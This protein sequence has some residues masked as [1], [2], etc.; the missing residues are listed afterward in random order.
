P[1]SCSLT[2]GSGLL[3]MANSSSTKK[4]LRSLF[5]KSE[6]DLKEPSEKDESRSRSRTLKLFRWK[7]KRQA[8][9]DGAVT[10]RVDSPEADEEDWPDADQK[11][12]IYATAP[13]SKPALETPLF[14][15]PVGV[16]S[17]IWAPGQRRVWTLVLHASS[18]MAGRVELYLKLEG[19]EKK[20]LSSSETDLHKPKRFSTFSLGW[21]KKK[22]K[23]VSFSQSTANI[24][25]EVTD[26]VGEAQI[27][28]QV[29]RAE[30][31][32][33]VQHEIVEPQSTPSL[34][35]TDQPHQQNV[36]NEET[37]EGAAGFMPANIDSTL[38]SYIDSDGDGYHTPPESPGLLPEVF[39]YAHTDPDSTAPAEPSSTYST[40]NPDTN[41]ETTNIATP[42]ILNAST[43]F[44]RSTT[45]DVTEPV[46][47]SEIPAPG[48]GDSSP[49]CLH[50]QVSEPASAA[51][52]ITSS[53]STVCSYSISLTK[54]R[55]LSS[56]AGKGD[57]S[58]T[59]QNSGEQE[60]HISEHPVEAVTTVNPEVPSQ[61]LFT[62]GSPPSSP[63]SS[64]PKPTEQTSSQITYTT[65]VPLDV[66]SKTE[67]SNTDNA[68][69]LPA[70]PDPKIPTPEHS[71]SS[72]QD[73]ADH[74]HWVPPSS[75]DV[76]GDSLQTSGSTLKH[77]HTP[78]LPGIIF[79]ST[80][81][82][83]SSHDPRDLEGVSASVDASLTSTHDSLHPILAAVQPVC[84][85]SELRDESVPSPLGT[86]TSLRPST[87]VG[88]DPNDDFSDPPSRYTYMERLDHSGQGTDLSDQATPEPE[89]WSLET[90]TKVS[91]NTDSGGPLAIDP[92][93][94]Y[95]SPSSGIQLQEEHM[96]ANSSLEAAGREEPPISLQEHG[97]YQPVTRADD[98]ESYNQRSPLE[99]LMKVVS[100]ERDVQM[101]S[102]GGEKVEEHTTSQEGWMEQV[103]CEAEEMVSPCYI[104]ERGM[105]DQKTEA[106]QFPEAQD[107]S[108]RES[109]VLAGAV[110]QQLSDLAITK[111]DVPVQ[112][113]RVPEECKAAPPWSLHGEVSITDYS[114]ATYSYLGA[115]YS[116]SLTMLSGSVIKPQED[117][118]GGVASLHAEREDSSIQEQVTLT[119]AS[120]TSREDTYTHLTCTGEEELSKTRHSQEEE[121]STAETE[122]SQGTSYNATDTSS[123]A[124]RSAFSADTQHQLS[125]QAVNSTTDT[126]RTVTDR[127]AGVIVYV[128]EF[129]LQNEIEDHPTGTSALP[130]QPPAP[131][132]TSA[133][134]FSHAFPALTTV[135]EESDPESP[136]E[137][138]SGSD[139]EMNSGIGVLSTTLTLKPKSS[140]EGREDGKRVRK[141]SLVNSSS[142]SASRSVHHLG[143]DR[144]ADMNGASHEPDGVR[145]AQEF[146][147]VREESKPSTVDA[148]YSELSGN[149][150]LYSSL[151]SSRYEPTTY[152][153]YSY[154]YSSD[155][156][157][158]S[159]PMDTTSSLG[160]SSWWNLRSEVQDRNENELNG[161]RWEEL[162]APAGAREV[163]REGGITNTGS[164][165]LTQQSDDFFS[166]VFKATRVELPSSPT[167]ADP[168]PAPAPE[169]GPEPSMPASP[170]EMDTLLDTLKSMGPP[171]R[172]R[173]LRNSSTQP[174]SSLPPIVE[175]APVHLPSPISSPTSPGPREVFSSLPPDLGLNWSSMK[176]M[177]S[178]LAM[179]KEQKSSEPPTRSL[180]LPS[181]ASAISSIVMRKSSLP[182]LNLEDGTQ[183]N[184]G[185]SFGMSRLDHSLIFS[186]YRSE[187][188]ENGKGLG[189]RSLFR[190]AS[191][192]E[193]SSGL[194]RL[195]MPPKATDTLGSGTSRLERL[196]F[197]TSPPGSLTE[198]KEPSR[199][200]V[201]PSFLNSSTTESLTL[202]HTPP[203]SLEIYRTLSPESPVK[204]PTPPSLQRSLSAEGLSI[205]SPVFN[206]GLRG[207]G[208]AQEPAP[209][210]SFVA[211]YRAFPDAYLTKEK[212][213]GKLNP[214]PGKMLIYDQPG[215]CGQ[216]IEVRG[217]VID[218]TAWQLPRTISIR[219]IRGGWVLYEKPDF[220][221]EKIALDEGDIELSDPFSP[222][223]DESNPVQNGTQEPGEEHAEP[224]PERRFVIG[225]L[226]RAVRDYSVPEICLFPEENAEGKKIVF[227][228]TSEDS[229]IFGFPI[230][231]NSIIINAGL[232]LVFAE[233]FFQGAPRVLEVGGF[234]NPAAWGVTQ[235]Y[236]SSLHPLK[237]GE[238]RVEKPNEPKLVIYE[239]PYFTGKSREIYT[240]TRDFMTREERQQVAFMYSAGSI[241]VLGGIWVGYEKEGFRGHQY[242]LEEGEYHDWRVWGGCDSELR[243]VR[244]I[245][246]DLSQPMLVMFEMQNEEQEA[247][248][249][250]TFE[251]TE[252]V[253]DVHTQF[254]FPAQGPALIIPCAEIL[255]DLSQPM[256]VMFEMQNEEQEA[257][258]ERTFE[259]TEA[260]PDVEPFGF[261]PATRSIHVLSGAWVAYSH[262]DYSGNQYVLEKGFYNNCADWGSEDNR[263]CS[264]QPILQAQAEGS[265]F[266]S[267]LLLY[268]EPAFQGVCQVYTRSHEA[269]PEK[270]SIKSCRVIGE[271]WVLYSSTN[272]QGEQ[273]VL[274]EGDYCNFS[275]MGCPPNCSIRSVK[276]VP[277]IFSVPSISLFGLECFEGRE[278]TMESEVSN[279]MDEG[280]NT[281]I[282][283]VRVNSGCWVLCEHTNYRGRQFL[284][285]PI[286]IT[287]WHKFSSLSSVS[288][289]YPIRA[290]RRLFRIRYKETGHYMSVQGGVD[291][292]KSGRVVV[293]N[294][295]E[296]MSDIW[297]YQDG[298]IKNKL[299]Q[300]MSLQVM[301]NVES[302]AKVVLWSETRS[303]VQTWSA[304]LSGTISSLT[305]PGLLLDVKGG[306]TYDKE[307][308]IVRIDTE[309]NSGLWE[310]EL[311]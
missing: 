183:V 200:S 162:S 119:E 58:F 286:E 256:L 201:S 276:S 2:S 265:S 240:N 10:S 306:K 1:G 85:G 96:D 299:A 262:V 25:G 301:G 113:E 15:Q 16:H 41:T 47:S 282:L 122:D 172:H 267:E 103:K 293:S 88:T 84:H 138:A 296:G 82:S 175:D 49:V 206:E 238:P 79:S 272:F 60:W 94:S 89:L 198:L 156:P 56:A 152:S 74:N 67:H 204:H 7:K 168:E 304:Q 104:S 90:V 107:L 43:N 73:S 150:H 194:D 52:T 260:V 26:H 253:P 126:S 233:P 216:R 290:K 207:F 170:H 229:R 243:S 100:D 91:P 297:F 232:W 102:A 235:P 228:D 97:G 230:K 209:E 51:P 307:H 214:R 20:L 195:S 222:E 284:L 29:D 202:N 246:T 75:R 300:N 144:L 21:R 76:T 28:D 112:R 109:E 288:S 257:Q 143:E 186:N 173:S 269:L 22:K 134:R 261:R 247:Q 36:C 189:H 169:P 81:L 54:G 180:V 277:M 123:A 34:V 199:I 166:G 203:Q 149:T 68:S 234:P 283:S 171:V 99:N 302:G 27:E 184:G 281:H 298:L 18:G 77:P 128:R 3:D 213:H 19:L 44:T 224:K 132:Y 124:S 174:F 78:V 71:P 142:S 193:V 188:E 227:R 59:P 118:A 264:I 278:V 292:L 178:P 130:D 125:L 127:G 8:E 32:Q 239:K 86:E 120:T 263:I 196:S 111:P 249:E 63:S 308:V 37:T 287:N 167:D 69:G 4:S 61:G 187:T 159:V 208:G 248:E 31:S 266:R 251:V 140:E 30:F 311:L 158:S 164:D 254:G 279:M 231:A 13:R 210:R 40:L 45:P 181:R 205:G 155:A 6:V 274:S 190:T 93:I 5:S 50:A 145:N 185:S 46:P 87:T 115:G 153:S 17:T 131:S 223:E 245:R 192:P 53:T 139:T 225:S 285:E 289:M 117:T 271:S 146:G 280:Y 83:S 291:N 236:V 151:S 57:L 157:P 160:N 165:S 105:D 154:S 106:H 95:H 177:R 309:E 294:Q 212:E 244:V 72:K 65:D 252:A 141:V 116:P 270:L 136:V 80:E 217:D 182:D 114:P 110:A 221:G 211:K 161:R 55:D 14:G 258:E 135:A 255:H 33:P 219:V 133:G 191:L 218:A 137:S 237:I 268:S 48:S 9:G 70:T 197:L 305:F 220:K 163:E 148:S 295:V 273:Y 101:V 275:S 129:G 241:K 38:I 92:D 121:I 179:M 98:L 250:R 310:L 23:N 108:G 147:S 39:V 242:L 42:G 215:L 24:S 35:L 226:R 62:P 259:V 176:D 66:Y 303:P 64:V 11:P 12:S